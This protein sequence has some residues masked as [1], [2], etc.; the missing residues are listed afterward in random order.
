MKTL[1][2]ITLIGA[3]GLASLGVVMAQTNP[4]QTKYE[5]YALQRLNKFL[6][7]DVCKGTQG[8]I[9]NLLNLKCDKLV[10]SAN[11]QMRLVIA[12]TTEREN[13]LLFSVYRTEIKVSSWLPGYKLETVGAFNQFYTYNA[14]EQ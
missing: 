3:T 10:A 2:I 12:D 14:G 6:T 7:T 13:Y 11:P 4:E 1:T 9:E 8:L 5:D